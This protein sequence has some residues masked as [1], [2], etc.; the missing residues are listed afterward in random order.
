MVEEIVPKEELAELF[1]YYE[2]PTIPATW[3]YNHLQTRRPLLR[4][5]SVPQLNAPIAPTPPAEQSDADL[6]QTESGVTH[7]VPLLDV[8]VP[9]VSRPQEFV[10]RPSVLEPAGREAE[11]MSIED[12]LSDHPMRSPRSHLTRRSH[13]I[14]YS[15]LSLL[16]L[17]QL[18]CT[19]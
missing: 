6:R 10:L 17:C 18:H 19:S 8:V 16:L 7:P 14:R 9:G 13:H 1:A 12:D 3:L 2:S 4:E 11:A 5:S 15:Q